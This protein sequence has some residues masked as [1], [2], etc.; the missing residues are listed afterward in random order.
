MEDHVDAYERLLGVLTDISRWLEPVRLEAATFSDSDIVRR[1]LV[2]LYVDIISFWAKA[3]Q[4]YTNSTSRRVLALFRTAWA[5]YENDY[6]ALQT[7]MEQDL[8]QFRAA[9]QAQH[10]RDSQI[11]S[12][13]LLNSN[14]GETLFYC[15]GLSSSPRMAASAIAN[16][17]L[18]AARMLHDA[19]EQAIVKWLGPPAD[20]PYGIDF[21]EVDRD[22]AFG[23]KHGGSCEWILGH[24][25][26][27]KWRLSAANS[28][29]AFLWIN[30]VPGAGKTVLSA[31]LTLHAQAAASGQ[32]HPPLYFLFRQADSNK[33]TASAAARSLLFQALS[34]ARHT[35]GLYQ[36]M[37]QT[38]STAKA[39]NTK[40]FQKIWALL[41]HYL[42]KAGAQ[43]LIVDAIDECVDS[44]TIINGLNDVIKRTSTRIIATSRPGTLLHEQMLAM[45]LFDMGQDQI[46]ADI[47]AYVEHRTETGPLSAPQLRR[48]VIDAV[49]SK[50]DG[51]FL[52]VKLLLDDL[53][54]KF[55]EQEVL[56][57]LQSIPEGLDALFV[58]ILSRLKATRKVSEQRFS[59]HVLTWLTCASWPLT[60]VVLFEA[61][62]LEYR[63]ESFIYTIESV[64]G[65]IERS[66]G[67][68]V[69]IRS[70]MV[71]L[72]HFSAKEF[73]L[74]NSAC[75]A[76]N[77]DLSVFSIS[78]PEGE[79]HLREAYLQYLNENV[80]QGQLRSP[81]EVFKLCDLDEL[82]ELPPKRREVLREQI[83]Y[84]LNG[85]PGRKLLAECPFIDYVVTTRL[86][87]AESISTDSLLRVNRRLLRKDTLLRNQFRPHV[88][89]IRA[90][91]GK[92]SKDEPQ[93]KIS[94]TPFEPYPKANS[95]AVQ[96]Q[97]YTCE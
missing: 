42:I 81:G 82:R 86:R 10:H 70:G 73:L 29:C 97:F 5:N 17:I 83:V 68:L 88:L 35:P 64:Q 45:T 3:I 49:V 47:A 54:S 56:N 7:S 72:I 87:T 32:D 53:A 44:N 55:S 20:A 84:L 40:S 66:C 95:V 12:Q 23:D 93:G 36:Q 77:E 24:P 1:S 76:T 9:T 19:E 69:K 15:L 33:N 96:T 52:W 58:T 39:E 57:A 13:I 21:Y 63:K 74:S 38:I 27:E 2:A 4:T 31:F 46:K 34:R 8:S 11:M 62:K 71:Q 6:R 30:A 16:S 92:K 89:A 67:P 78:Q 28:P 18:E 80:F 37:L 90:V 51:M 22:S 14:E 94:A 41:F 50:A 61:L 85:I 91:S 25:K 43:V 59:R 65:A 48:P 26:Y 60:L 75:W 79:R